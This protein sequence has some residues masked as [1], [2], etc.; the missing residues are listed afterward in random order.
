MAW[1]PP[2]TWIISPVIPADRSENR[3][4]IARPT[5]VGS[6]MS[7]PSGARRAQASAICSNPGMPLPA[8][9]FSGPADTVFTRIPFGPRSRAR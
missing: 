6:V 9:V 2:S 1:K 4:A 7:H 5:G 3:N 8:M